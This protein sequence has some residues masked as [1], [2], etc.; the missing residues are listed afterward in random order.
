[1]FDN[2]NHVPLPFRIAGVMYLNYNCH[3]ESV[4]PACVLRRKVV[5]LNLTQ[6]S[7]LRGDI[8]RNDVLTFAKISGRYAGL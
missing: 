7:S 1:M 4:L 5:W 8:S 2:C 3:T 6:Q